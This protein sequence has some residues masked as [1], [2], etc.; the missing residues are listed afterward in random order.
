MGQPFDPY[1]WW[2]GIRDPER[3]PNHYRLLGVEEFEADPDVIAMAADR[4]MTHLRTLQAGAQAELSQ[5]ILNE[6]SAAR[7]CLL[8]P[9]RKAA[10]DEQLRRA[11]AGAAPPAAKPSQQSAAHAAAQVAKR[12]VVAPAAEETVATNSLLSE[13]SDMASYPGRA[14]AKKSAGASRGKSSR[15]QMKLWPWLAAAAVSA[16]VAVGIAMWRGAENGADIATDTTRHATPS[17]PLGK[18]TAGPAPVPRRGEGREPNKNLAI[19]AATEEAGAE[20]PSVPKGPK[21]S[22]RLAGVRG[23]GSDDTQQRPSVALIPREANTTASPAV[24]TPS[25]PIGPDAT[26]IASPAEAAP[27]TDKNVTDKK[28]PDTEPKNLQPVTDPAAT[29]A[30][31]FAAADRGAPLKPAAKPVRV[32]IPS[33]P[34]QAAAEQVILGIYKTDLDQANRGTPAMKISLAKKLRQQAIDTADDPGARYLL[35]IKAQE[36]AASGGDAAV[37]FSVADKLAER[38][39]IEG[40]EEKFN[41]LLA[42]QKNARSPEALQALLPYANN[43]IDQAIADDKYDVASKIAR[44]ASGWAAK[45]HNPQLVAQAKVRASEIEQTKKEYAKSLE[46]AATLERQPD[47]PEANFAV[48]YFEGP[49]KG[50]FI[51]AL[52]KLAKG[53]EPKYRELAKNELAEPTDAAP[54]AALADGWWSLA[55]DK[56]EPALGNLHW[57]AA[58]WYK[59]ALSDLKGLTMAQAEARIKQAKIEHPAP[60]APDEIDIVRALTSGDWHITWYGPKSNYSGSIWFQYPHTKFSRDGTFK[61]EDGTG[62]WTLDGDTA[63]VTYDLPRLSHMQQ[64]YRLVDDKLRCEHYD[65]PTVLASIGVGIRNPPP[66][67]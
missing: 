12:A 1:L 5:R 25:S 43:A 21:E 42:L 39:A 2:L 8:K 51:K 4:Q 6:L 55:E 48:G 16:A 35:F 57:H 47:D 32:A 17:P 65:P 44:L 31:P 11:M 34:A 9:E 41:L 10:Y 61:D 20:K 59:L 58:G 3:P 64:R 54:R 24:Q 66:A 67:K 26:R 52:P 30:V 40:A 37:A 14:S 36:L 53:S 23:S 7:L 27:S 46:S 60:V 29:A 56:H 50:D 19:V 63:V 13:L 22:K 62:N 33:K 49:I 45:L 38:F 15:G 28:P 18:F